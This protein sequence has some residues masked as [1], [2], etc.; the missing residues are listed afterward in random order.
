MWPEAIIFFSNLVSLE[1]WLQAGGREKHLNF[2]R[3]FELSGCVPFVVSF[4]LCFSTARLSEIFLT[5][6]TRRKSKNVPR[7]PRAPLLA[8]RECDI[9]CRFGTCKGSTHGIKIKTNSASVSAVKEVRV[10][11]HSSRKLCSRL[12][13]HTI[14]VVESESSENVNDNWQVKKYLI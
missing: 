5:K 13:R 14:I 12:K 11:R 2:C 4:S 10:I 9:A 1:V 3:D 7:T 6:Q 8:P